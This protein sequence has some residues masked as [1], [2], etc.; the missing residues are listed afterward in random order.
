MLALGTDAE[1]TSEMELRGL[2]DG[3]GVRGEREGE[4]KGD[5]WTGSLCSRVSRR[6]V[7]GVEFCV[8]VCMKKT[9]I[10]SGAR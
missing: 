5:F 6:A 1:Y 3:Q 4:L 7:S 8:C 10:P 9:R 2:A